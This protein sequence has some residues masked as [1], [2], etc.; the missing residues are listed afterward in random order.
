MTAICEKHVP[1]LK[2]LIQ[3]LGT[4]GANNWT[5]IVDANSALNLPE[6]DIISLDGATIYSWYSGDEIV[7]SMCV[8]Y[9]GQKYCANQN[10]QDYDAE[11]SYS[12]QNVQKGYAG[13]NLCEIVGDIEDIDQFVNTIGELIKQLEV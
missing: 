7:G 1:T 13:Q 12:N 11:K 5:K 6:L 9:L 10:G 2:K 3:Y 4:N 8:K